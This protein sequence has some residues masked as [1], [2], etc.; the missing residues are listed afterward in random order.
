MAKN[1]PKVEVKSSDIKKISKSISKAVKKVSREVKKSRKKALN[2]AKGIRSRLEKKGYDLGDLDLE[3]MST[4]QLNK[5]D[6]KKM[7]QNY[8]T[9]ES[10][11]KIIEEE[12]ALKERKKILRQQKRKLEKIRKKEQEKV[13]SIDEAKKQD[14]AWKPGD[15]GV[16]PAGSDAKIQIDKII[17]IIK[18]GESYSTKKDVISADDAVQ[19]SATRIMSM[20]LQARGKYSDEVIVEKLEKTFGSMD[21]VAETVERLIYAIYDDILAEW[22]DGSSAYESLISTISGALGV[23]DPGF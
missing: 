18:V 4:R 10:V 8:A 16:I 22:A 13:I 23:R 7:I 19:P 15:T 5:L 11:D 6:R 14:A 2:R 3:S 1:Y 9:Q 20:F 17:E 12:R 21:K